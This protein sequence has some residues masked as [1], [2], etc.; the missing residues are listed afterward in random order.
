MYVPFSDGSGVTLVAFAKG[1]IT[2]LSDNVGHLEV[3]ILIPG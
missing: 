1:F 2:N 3:C